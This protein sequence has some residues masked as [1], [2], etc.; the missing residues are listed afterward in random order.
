MSVIFKDMKLE[1]AT[2]IMSVENRNG[3]KSKP[4]GL[5]HQATGEKGKSQQRRLRRS[6]EDRRYS[7][8]RWWPSGG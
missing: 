8:R 3:Q 2:K 4:W 5:Q 6:Q 7:R 1:K